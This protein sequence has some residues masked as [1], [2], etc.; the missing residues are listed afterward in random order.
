MKIVTD[1]AADLPAEEIK[2]LGITIV[3]LYIQFPDGEVN[4][5]DL[6]PDEFYDLLE[7]MAPEIPTTAMPSPGEIADLYREL[8]ADGDEIISIHL[9]LGLSGTGQAARLGASEVPEADISVVDTMT[10]AG[11][12]RFQ[13]LA[14][15]LGARAG[16]EKNTI[17]ERLD[18]I[19]AETE[20]IF[21]LDTLD[22]LAKGGR[23]GRVSALAGSLLHIKP[24]IHVDKADGKYSTVG[25]AR[26]MRR[27]E[28]KIV[29]HLAQ[30]YGTD[31][32]LWVVVQHGRLA[33]EAEAFSESL[34]SKLNIARL[35]LLRVSP[36]LGVHTGPGIVGVGVVPMA[37]MEDLS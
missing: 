34:R 4:A 13:V 29:E 23:I 17:L 7:A 10:L 27:A 31:T 11:G 20:V 35:D 26:S 37:L 36:I 8:A 24:V 2:S 18:R 9:S 30:L 6:T 12:Q 19:R 15:V 25:K 3:P 21:T 33:A 28:A 5:S 14:A 22:Y 16:W 1:C 32:P